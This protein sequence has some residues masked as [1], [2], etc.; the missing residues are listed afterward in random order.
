MLWCGTLWQSMVG[1]VWYGVIYVLEWYCAKWYGIALAVVVMAEAA[2]ATVVLVI[3]VA[4]IV[5]CSAS[6]VEFLL[7]VTE[8]LLKKR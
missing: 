5:V 6:Y 2:A 1:I 7:S 4:V 8:L 3:A